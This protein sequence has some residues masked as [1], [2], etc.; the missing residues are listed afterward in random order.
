MSQYQVWQEIDSNFDVPTAA[1]YPILPIVADFAMTIFEAYI[2]RFSAY[3]RE[4][5]FYMW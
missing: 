4:K 2:D 3:N 5:D 1:K